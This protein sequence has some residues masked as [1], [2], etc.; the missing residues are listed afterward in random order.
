MKFF[1]KK[2]IPIAAAVAFACVAA[3]LI[4]ARFVEPELLTLTRL[5]FPVAAWTGTE[6]RV[7]AVVLSDLHLGVGE[8]EKRRLARIVEKTL[9]QKPDAVFLLGDYEKGV[10]R[11]GMMD[12]GTFAEGLRPLAATVPVFACLGNHDPYYGSEALIRA[13]KSVGARLERKGVALFSGGR[14]NAEMRIVIALDPDSYG[15]VEE[16]F[17]AFSPNAGTPTVLLVHS[18]D[19]FPLLDETRGVDFAFC[20]HT[21]GGQICLPFGVPLCTS[22]RVVGRDFAHGLKDFP[23][24]GKMFVTRGLGTSV[25]PMRLFCPPEIVVVDFVPAAP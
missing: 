19:V 18:P 1:A 7:R 24:G 20:G 10:R 15:A 12:A 14:G 25:L 23:A 17:P 3:V 6:K 5:E 16:I 13:L 8:S 4:W 21:H 22:S 11:D 9:A 2:K